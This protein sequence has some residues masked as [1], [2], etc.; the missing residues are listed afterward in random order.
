MPWCSQKLV[1]GRPLPPFEITLCVSSAEEPQLLLWELF[2]HFSLMICSSAG[3]TR[4]EMTLQT[5]PLAA[6]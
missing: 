4:V 1:K 3:G 2:F 6:F 5:V